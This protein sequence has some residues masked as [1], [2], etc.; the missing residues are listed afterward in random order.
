MLPQKDNVM[1]GIYAKIAHGL[2][3]ALMV[4]GLAHYSHN[5]PTM[6][7]LFLRVSLG[8]IISLLVL[9]IM[10][11][12]LVRLTLKSSLYYT[13]RAIVSFIGLFMYIET[14]KNIGV[15]ETMAFAY[16]PIWMILFAVILFKES[17]TI[18][19]LFII[20]LNMMGVFLVLQPKL[21]SINFIGMGQ[22]L[23]STFLFS[24]YDTICKKQAATEHYMVQC[25]YSFVF[26]AILVLPFIYYIWQPISLTDLM[27]FSVVA[28]FGVANV[29]LMF[30]AYIYT[31]IVTL[32]PFG[33][34]KLVFSVILSFLLY[35]IYPS[36]QS[37]LGLGLIISADWYFYMMQK[38]R[39]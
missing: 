8:A 2:M 18:K 15:N 25:F 36:T 22:A 33:Y 23:F 12:S 21:S 34:S 7:V 38:M 29:V 10:R 30:I 24:I 20:L 16:T 32:L 28:M 17:F 35:N 11:K 26:S 6:Q 4:I 5:F 19:H 27:G 1:L 9:L 37:L 3:V 13:A 39:Q 31:P 14:V